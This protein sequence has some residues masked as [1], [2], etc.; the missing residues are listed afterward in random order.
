MK[1]KNWSESIWQQLHAALEQEKAICAKKSHRPVA[2]F[3]ADGTLWNLDLGEN[4]FRYQIANCNLSGLPSDPWDHY[5]RWKADGDPRPAYLWLAQINAGQ[6]I[7]QVQEW[8]LRA[9]QNLGEQA[10]FEDQRRWIST[11]LANDVEVFIVTASVK[12]AVEPGAAALG[13]A[14]DHVLGVQTR[15]DAG[16]VTKEAYSHMTYREGKAAA[17]LEATGGR[18]PFFCAGNT[19]GDLALLESAT[20][21]RLA[22][23]TRP[24]LQTEELIRSERSL[25]DAAEQ[26]SWLTH[27]F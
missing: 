19:L 10:Y 9:A 21:V 17:L 8:A 27:E 23:R 1:Y 15:I 13:I 26:R 2:A 18:L 12:W 16:T 5:A 11:L 3:D 25:A 14:A 4:F 22:L 7:K 20:Q 6:S 24:E